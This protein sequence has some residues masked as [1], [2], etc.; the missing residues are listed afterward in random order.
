M[1]KQNRN[2]LRYREQTD[3]WQI[4]GRLGGWVKKVK[5][6]KTTNW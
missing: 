2:R 3:G 6:V 1:N 4:G 5:V